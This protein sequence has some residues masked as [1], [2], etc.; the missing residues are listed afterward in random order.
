MER[1]A[2]WKKNKPIFMQL[3]SQNGSSNI[4]YQYIYQLGKCYISTIQSFVSHTDNIPNT[5]NDIIFILAKTLKI[6]TK[7]NTDNLKQKTDFCPRANVLSFK[8]SNYFNF[9]LT[10]TNITN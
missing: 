4:T 6:N 9:M 1:E 10:I 8:L 5:Y 3:W 7:T 2:S